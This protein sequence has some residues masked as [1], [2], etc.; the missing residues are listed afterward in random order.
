[1]S[2]HGF[3]SSFNPQALGNKPSM[4]KDIG[5][6]PI[7]FQNIKT[8][9]GLAITSIKSFNGIVMQQLKTW[10]GLPK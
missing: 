3:R 4:D 5:P 7:L 8:I 1:M 6:Y 10:V 9:V 2:F